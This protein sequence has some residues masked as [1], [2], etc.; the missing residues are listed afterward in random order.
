[1]I[2]I[3]LGKLHWLGGGV[4]SNV[5]LFNTCVKIKEN[6]FLYINEL[7]QALPYSGKVTPFTMVV[8]C[9]YIISAG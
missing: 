7:L 4:I 2:F 1:M 9:T 5:V 3:T 6:L 8:I